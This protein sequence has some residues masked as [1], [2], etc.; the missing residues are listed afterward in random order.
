M[1]GACKR[2]DLVLLEQKG[3]AL[4]Q[5]VDHLVLAAQHLLEVERDGGD[6]D[7]VIGEMRRGLDEFF[8][9]LQQRLRRDTADIEAGTAEHA[10]LVD[11]GDLH[12]ELR[13]ADRRDIAARPGADDDQIEFAVSH[14]SVPS[15]LR[16][17]GE[18]VRVPRC[19][20]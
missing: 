12:A 1:R 2:L 4:G 7:P 19:I 8:G 10:A 3:D 20:P 5:A 18:C 11:A 17:P 9:T 16:Y 6:L 13:R 14:S 15:R